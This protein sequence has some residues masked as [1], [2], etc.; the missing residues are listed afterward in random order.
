VKVADN[1]LYGEPCRAFLVDGNF[2]KTGKSV[3]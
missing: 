3:G 2:V 1:A